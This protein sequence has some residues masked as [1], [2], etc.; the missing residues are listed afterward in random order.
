MK[1]VRLVSLLAAVAIVGCSP[2]SSTS[3]APASGGAKKL[4]GLS[5]DTLKEA[6]WA[7]D[8]DLFIAK[9][10]ELGYEVKVQS[11]NGDDVQQI[12]DVEQLVTLGCKSV[13]IVPH[14]G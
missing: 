13:V 5:L 9:C 10:K 4:I 6:R 3:S 11:A 12:R 1:L 8:R 2:K 14:N 7:S